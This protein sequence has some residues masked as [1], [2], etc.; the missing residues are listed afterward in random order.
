MITFPEINPHIVKIG[1]FEIRW[2]GLLYVIAF[3]IAYFFL[4]KTLP[5][6]NVTMERQKYEDLL[7]FLMLGVIVGGRLGYILFYNLK[8]YIYHPFEVF[9][10]WQGGMSFHGG[11]LGVIIFGLFSAKKL[12]FNFLAVADATMG[13][14]A[15]GLGLGRLGNFLN[16]ELYGKV[17]NVPWAMIFPNSDGLPRH[18][19]QLYEMFLEGVVLSTICFIL[20]QKTRKNGIV[21][22]SFIG[23]Y[24]LFRVLVE[25]VREPDAH[26]GYIYSFLTMG[27]IL[28]LIM[29]LSSL[30]GFIFIFRKNKEIAVDV[31]N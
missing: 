23:I 27:Q 9:A 21:F 28:S 18:P 10:V 14:V 12:K 11:A 15:I 31:E 1:S 17:T 16:A 13:W 6:R 2:Y 7:F 30:I 8:Y 29:I 24:G 5:K 25:F 19:S 3:A 4:K 22:W 26:L 20:L